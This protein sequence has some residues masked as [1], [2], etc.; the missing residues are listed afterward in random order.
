M[1]IRDADGEA[2]RQAGL[3]RALLRTGEIACSPLTCAGP[4]ED[5]IRDAR[6]EARTVRTT[7][8]M[9]RA[10]PHVGTTVARP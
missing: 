10:A 6:H 2:R 1:D 4:A 7:I 9:R 5:H 3:P 8:A